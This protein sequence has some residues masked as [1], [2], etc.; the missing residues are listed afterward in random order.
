MKM[1]CEFLNETPDELISDIKTSEIPITEMEA[2]HRKL[3][4][5]MKNTLKMMIRS[6]DQR[7]NA[8]HSF[9]RANGIRLTPEIIRQLTYVTADVYGL[10][11]R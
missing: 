7:F 8:L 10:P 2:V 3:A 1:F 4:L 9:Y 6:I 11:R 5:Y